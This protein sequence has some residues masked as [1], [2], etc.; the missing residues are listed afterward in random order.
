MG[1]IDL[2]NKRLALLGLGLEHRALAAYL[3]AAGLSFSVCD[4]REVATVEE[5]G[6]AVEEWRFGRGYLDGLEDFEQGL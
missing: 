6:F 2:D 5:S 4:E 3:S 1:T